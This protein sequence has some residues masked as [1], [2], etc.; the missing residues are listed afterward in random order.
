MFVGAAK[1]V[2]AGAAGH[3]R[4][5]IVTAVQ[6]PWVGRAALLGVVPRDNAGADGYPLA[7]G[8]KHPTADGGVSV[9]MVRA[10][11]INPQSPTVGRA[12][13]ECVPPWL[14]PREAL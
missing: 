9:E 7:I 6:Q 10:Q 14:R 11:G 3:E 1:E 4:S 2:S 13:S 5:S 8:G 12:V